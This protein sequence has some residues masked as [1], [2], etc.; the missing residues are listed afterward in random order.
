MKRLKSTTS[1][2]ALSVIFA[3][4]LGQGQAQAQA[5]P[6]AGQPPAEAAAPSSDKVE[7]VVVTATR[8]S[9]EIQKTPMSVT[10]ITGSDLEGRGTNSVGD[11]VAVV[12]GVST[13][14][15]QPGGNDITVRG[16][17][18]STTTFSQTDV[19]VNS[20]TS[21]Y[22]NQLPVTSTIT[23]MPDFRFVDVERIEVLRGPQGT[24]YG[25]SSIGGL[26]KLITNKPDASEF[27]GNIG[28]YL[29]HTRDGGWNTGVD[30]HVN[31]P[32]AD[33]L[34]ARLV[35]Y[36]Y[37]NDGFIDVVCPTLDKD[38]NE[39][40]TIGGR[41]ALDRD[42]SNFGNATCDT[43]ELRLVSNDEDPFIDWIL[44]AYYED[45]S[46][47][48]RAFAQ[49]SGAPLPVIPPF[50]FLNPGDIAID[51][52]RDLTYEE[53]AFYG[54]LGFNLSDEWKFTAVAQAS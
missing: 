10:A 5:T 20:T 18:T 54:E 22:L 53:L 49:M 12:P 13:L 37:E 8:R 17:N 16:V 27:F 24:L 28:G 3:T 48:L 36:S 1:V 41:A 30:C 34:A 39:E 45:A 40:H 23:K 25:Q 2:I 9:T 52:G 19:I 35:G 29:S 14:T 42:I 15:N 32:L 21:I 51:S 43:A 4:T 44:G 47:E 46:D 50:F 33:N 38:A 26:V 7:K 11:A 31:A 6:P